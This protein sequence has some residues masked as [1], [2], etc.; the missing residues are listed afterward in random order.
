MLGII[1]KI[2]CNK[3]GKVY[4]GSTKEPL[5]MRMSKHRADM[6]LHLRGINRG[7]RRVFEVLENGDWKE[8]VI[9]EIEFED[10]KDLYRREGFHQLNNE[11]VNY[12]I[13]GGMRYHK[14]RVKM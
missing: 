4:I 9:E 14:K 5:C 11:C 1:Y 2:T 10:K 6:R 8:E 3:T 12:C 7:K 13:G